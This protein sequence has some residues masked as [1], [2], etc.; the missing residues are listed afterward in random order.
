MDKVSP[1]LQYGLEKVETRSWESSDSLAYQS[2][3]ESALSAATLDDRELEDSDAQETRMASY[4]VLAVE[5]GG[6][7]RSRESTAE[8]ISPPDLQILQEPEHGSCKPKESYGAGGAG[9]AEMP[10]VLSEADAAILEV[11]EPSPPEVRSKKSAYR[12]AN[13]YEEAEGYRPSP[14][15]GVINLA[16]PPAA[17]PPPSSAIASSGKGGGAGESSGSSTDSR[18]TQQCIQIGT[19]LPPEKQNK[20]IGISLEGADLWRRFYQV[21]TEMIITKSGR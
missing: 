10:G 19:Y 4:S 14:P 16:P 9:T 15:G 7:S 5:G 6:Q 11:A 21:G 8:P 12:N 20:N 17:V 18:N 3:E 1:A 13:L 2:P